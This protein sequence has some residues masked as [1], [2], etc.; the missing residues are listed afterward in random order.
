MS[1]TAAR[2]SAPKHQCQSCRERKARFRFR[3]RVKADHH[4]TLCFR[5]FRAQ[6][7]ANRAREIVARRPS[8]LRSPFLA[9]PTLDE[10]QLTHRVRMLTHLRASVEGRQSA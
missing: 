3:G 9:A 7:E 2:E 4:H 5:C 8:P 10:R 6:R 1:F